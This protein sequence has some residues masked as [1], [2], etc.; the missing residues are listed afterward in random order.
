MD[1]GY[2]QAAK[3]DPKRLD[4][5]PPGVR[6]G[7]G[8]RGIPA[9][10][11][12]AIDPEEQNG[13]YATVGLLGRAHRRPKHCPLAAAPIRSGSLLLLGANCRKIG[14]CAMGFEGFDDLA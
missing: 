12:L 1:P 13:S 11:R 6:S 2:G 3:S 7:N 5:G 8:G 9:L 14:G 10:G 4:E